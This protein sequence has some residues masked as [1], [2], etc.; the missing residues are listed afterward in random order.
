[1]RSDFNGHLWREKR[2]RG[3]GKKDS[4][5]REGEGEVDFQ[6]ERNWVKLGEEGGRVVTLQFYPP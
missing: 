1:M 3:E 5:R 6:I 4:R 2:R